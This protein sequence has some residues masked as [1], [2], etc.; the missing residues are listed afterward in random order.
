MKCCEYGTSCFVG[1]ISWSAFQ[2]QTILSKVCANGRA[3]F[4]F[5]KLTCFNSETLTVNKFNREPTDVEHLLVLNWNKIIK[6]VDVT[7]PGK[8]LQLN[9]MFVRNGGHNPSMVR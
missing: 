9:L 7:V 2:W 3:Y 8:P 4:V 5:N 1:V 6:I